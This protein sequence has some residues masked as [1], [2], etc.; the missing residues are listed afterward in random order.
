MN[1]TAER[2]VVRGPV[3]EP[4]ICGDYILFSQKEFKFRGRCDI[5]NTDYDLVIDASLIDDELQE[6]PFLGFLERNLLSE[7]IYRTG[8]NKI[9]LDCSFKVNG[10]VCI[11]ASCKSGASFCH[12]AARFVSDVFGFNSLNTHYVNRRSKFC[13]NRFIDTLEAKYKITREE[14]EQICYSKE[15]LEY[16]GGGYVLI[17]DVVREVQKRNKRKGSRCTV[18]KQFSS[19]CVEYARKLFCSQ[20]CKESYQE[21]VLCRERILKQL[22]ESERDRQLKALAIAKKA[23]AEI[24]VLLKGPSPDR[25]QSLT[26]EL[27]TL[28]TSLK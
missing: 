3:E 18:C 17:R 12:D 26:E 15:Y 20:D 11:S 14:I 9:L 22:N 25:L 23:H 19:R 7:S 10:V 21:K 1:R 13:H 2:L 16:Q 8:Q 4:I 6:K 24:Q 5:G 28:E 27:K